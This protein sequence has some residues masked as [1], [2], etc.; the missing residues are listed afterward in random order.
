M[1]ISELASAVQA[2]TQQLV[3]IQ[4]EILDKIDELEAALADVEVPVE[5]TEALDALRG[6]AQTLD[7]IVPD[8]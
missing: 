5:A 4:T 1:K 2:I 3:K 8:A 7:D 6:A